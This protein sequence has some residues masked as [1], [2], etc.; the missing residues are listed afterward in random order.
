[1]VTQLGFVLPVLVHQSGPASAGAAG[2]AGA[3]LLLAAS[4]ECGLFGWL[5]SHSLLLEPA[6]YGGNLFS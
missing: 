5:S 1:M 4:V 6:G 3:A 2:A